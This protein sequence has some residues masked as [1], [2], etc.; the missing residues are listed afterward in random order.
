MREISDIGDT[1]LSY[2]EV[3]ALAAGDPRLI[4]QAEVS[5]ELARLERLERAWQRDRD[6]LAR[7]TTRLAAKDASL[8]RELDQVAAAQ[9]ARQVHDGD[10]PVVMVDGETYV[11]RAGAGAALLGQL[12]TATERL[13]PDREAKLGSVATVD[14]ITVEASAW[15]TANSR[16]VDMAL[17][18]V[19]RSEIRL[20]GPDLTNDHPHSVIVAIENRLRRLDHLPETIRAELDALAREQAAVAAALVRPFA[21]ATIDRLRARAV[22]LHEEITALADKPPDHTPGTEALTGP[23]TIGDLLDDSFPNL[24]PGIALTPPP[25]PDP[26]PFVQRDAGFER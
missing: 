9:L 8:R 10:R 1:A 19:P 7:E 2:A 3:K 16:G 11:Q 24:D 12:R 21:H 13:R 23:P 17:V 6:R 5:A 18:G 14:G 22:Q 20:Q 15:A 26:V 4:E 25:A